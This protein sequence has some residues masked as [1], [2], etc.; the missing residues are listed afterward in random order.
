MASDLGAGCSVDTS[1]GKVVPGGGCVVDARDGCVQQRALAEE[2]VV[3][4]G[5][6]SGVG[7]V[8]VAAGHI[9]ADGD[10]LAIHC[11]GLHK[12]PIRLL[13]TAG[14][15]AGNPRVHLVTSPQPPPNRAVQREEAACQ[16]EGEFHGRQE[17]RRYRCSAVKG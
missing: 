9:V 10:A 14:P 8:S 3:A 11:S 12:H 7:P 1:I 5:G 2:V 4:Q 13:E 6:H 15:L 17:E 16:Y